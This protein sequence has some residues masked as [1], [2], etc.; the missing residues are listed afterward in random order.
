MPTTQFVLENDYGRK[1]LVV[2]AN[3]GSVTVEK[4]V[5]ADWV[6]VDT[7]T[8]DGAWPLDLGNS[9]TRFTPADG[10]AFEVSK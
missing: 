10:A 9:K 7:F 5:G 2:K 1:I 8:T 4:M 3:N 6:V